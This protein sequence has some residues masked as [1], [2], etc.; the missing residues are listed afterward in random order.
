M[1]KKV[2]I[3]TNIPA[4]YRVDFFDYL[5]RNTSEYEITIVYANRKE[6]NRQWTVDEE[7]MG[8]SRFLDS[9][10]IKIPGKQ[11][12]RYMHVTRGI[13]RVL[14]EL[15]PD[16]VVGS[17]YNPTCIQALLYCR[18]KKIPYI[19]WTDGTLHSER[20]INRIQR[21]LRLFVVKHASAYIASSTRS[22]EAQMAYG[23]PE[24]R[25]FTSFL[26]VDVEKYLVEEEARTPG[27]MIC[28][29]SL[30]PRKGMDLLLNALQEIRQEF[31]LVIAG[32]GPEEENLKKQAKDLGLSESVE[33]LGHLSQAELR[34]EYA[35]SSLFVLPTRE[36]CFA[37]VILEA[38]CAGL[39]I[40]SSGYADG[41]YDLVTEGENG[42]IIDP[43]DAEAF[44]TCLRALLG[45]D[46]KL[47]EMGKAS[48]REIERFRFEEVSKGFL[49]AFAFVLE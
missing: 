44:G 20:N 5:S 28:V 49:D 19:S 3:F 29:G 17:E 30:I 6:D 25:C 46:K 41:A 38:M 35:K 10:T 48:R 31:R 15:K 1:M 11:D 33:F 34:K 47:V 23:A 36:D 8:N 39:P 24:K 9:F 37:L 21:F 45:D 40:V 13:G 18:R 14:K 2:V 12:T 42:Y 32:A 4:P 22:K 26:T 7:K 43:Y 16:I 27:R